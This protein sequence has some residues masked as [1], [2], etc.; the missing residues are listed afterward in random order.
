M[1]AASCAFFVFL[2]PA[3][4]LEKVFALA[5]AAALRVRTII[6]DNAF[7]CYMSEVEKIMDYDYLNQN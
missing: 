1:L 2:A 3:L 6:Q 5:P 4:E 7:F